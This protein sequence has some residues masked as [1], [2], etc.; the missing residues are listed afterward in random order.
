MAREKF[1]IG[2]AS[3][4]PPAANAEPKEYAFATFLGT[5]RADIDLSDMNVDIF[6]FR[7]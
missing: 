5:V 7:S 3:V 1:V 6:F 4:E 2:L